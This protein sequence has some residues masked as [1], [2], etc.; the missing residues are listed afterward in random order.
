[1]AYGEYDV[2]KS[3][4]H[5]WKIRLKEGRDDVFWASSVYS[6]IHNLQKCAQPHHSTFTLSDRNYF[7]FNGTLMTQLYHLSL[8][9]V[10]R[11]SSK[12][13]SLISRSV[14]QHSVN[15]H[16]AF[17]SAH[18][19]KVALELFVMAS[20]LDAQ[21]S[22]S[23]P[24]VFVWS[25]SSFLVLPLFCPIQRNLLHNVGIASMLLPSLCDL[26]F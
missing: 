21:D 14:L 13:L 16:L 19:I 3:R 10:K 2:K 8:R 15:L 9:T 6:F 5:K 26:L 25:T 7:D 24:H 18:N 4:V 11:S 20:S 23:S 22:F 12:N 17:L 1:L